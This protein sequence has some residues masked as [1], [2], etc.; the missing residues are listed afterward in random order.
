MASRKSNAVSPEASLF[1]AMRRGI[2]PVA[3]TIMDGEAQPLTA[4]ELEQ[5][6][7]E[8]LDR[9]TER[10]TATQRKRARKLLLKKNELRLERSRGRPQTWSAERL[11][12]FSGRYDVYYR[13]E[14]NYVGALAVLAKDFEITAGTAAKILTRA[15][16]LPT[17][18]SR[19]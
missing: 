5:M 3:T 13:D 16:Q 2:V 11:R 17:N 19:K 15:R 9:T 10:L 14:G 18:K 4:Q 6:S 8:W 1:E 12:V 7:R